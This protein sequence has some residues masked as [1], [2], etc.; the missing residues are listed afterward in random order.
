MRRSHMPGDYEQDIVSRLPQV[1][2]IALKDLLRADFGDRAVLLASVL[3]RAKTFVERPQDA[4]S[5]FNNF[6]TVEPG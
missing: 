1:G 2:D 4:V 3:E 6:L 5:A